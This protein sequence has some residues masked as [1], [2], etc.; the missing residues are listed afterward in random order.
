MTIRDNIIFGQTFEVSR[1][2]RVLQAC[3][4]L[5]DLNRLPGGDLAQVGE[6][7]TNEKE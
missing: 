1:Y 4:L 6:K 3:Q 7:V 2:E 5:D